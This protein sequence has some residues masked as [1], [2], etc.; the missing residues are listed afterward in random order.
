MEISEQSLRAL[1]DATDEQHR[2]GMASLRSDIG[3]LHS[4]MRRLRPILSRTTAQRRMLRRAAGTASLVTIGSQVLPVSSFLPRAA[5][6]GGDA[7]IAAFAES[8]EL[9]AVAAYDA[10]AKSGLVTT[11]AVLD[12]AVKFSGHHTEHAAAFGAAAGDAATGKLN[13]ALLD[14]LVPGLTA[15]KS[16]NDV[17]KLAYDLENAAA[18]TYL[19]ALGALESVGALQL[20]ASILPVEAQHAV[21]LG[22]VFGADAATLLPPFETETT[23]VDPTK[24]PVG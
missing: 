15:A 3:E 13:Q 9:T 18:A 14:A 22:Q 4:E 23:F 16:E 12:A 21:V 5:A 2:A 17:L 8:V 24:F 19:F 7:G 6:A 20:T 1:V 11:K 10:A